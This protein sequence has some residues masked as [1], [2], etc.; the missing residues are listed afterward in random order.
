LGRPF[1]PIAINT[2][3]AGLKD[4]ARR[5]TSEAFSLEK[6]L[7]TVRDIEQSVLESHYAEIVKTADPEY[8]TMMNGILS[9]TSVHKKI[10][11]ERI[12]QKKTKS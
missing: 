7:F 10:I 12:E 2:A 6:I 4:I 11:Q 9:D 1:N 3:M 5:L 8:Q